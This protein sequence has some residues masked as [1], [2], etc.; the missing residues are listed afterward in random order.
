MVTPTLVS[1]LAAKPSGIPTS[2]WIALAL[3]VLVLAGL[4]YYTLVRARERSVRMRGR[5]REQV[6][7]LSAE[8]IAFQQEMRLM[9][10]ARIV[11]KAT[12][13]AG[14]ATPAAPAEAA[15]GGQ[16]GGEPAN[17]PGGEAG[18]TSLPPVIV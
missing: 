1:A 18:G 8:Q 14:P 9:L 17:D 6:K 5:S 3:T 15:A 2:V 11:A 16:S 12:D 10:Q 13:P 7:G 4:G